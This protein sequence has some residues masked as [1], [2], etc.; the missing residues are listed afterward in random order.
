MK[1]LRIGIV[2]DV[3]LAQE[4]LKRFV[5]SVNEFEV[6]WVAA[7]GREA[8]HK[9]AKDTPDLILMD[10]IMPEMDGVAATR[11]IMKASPC[12]ILIVTSS[13]TENSPKVFEAMGCGALDVVM[14]PTIALTHD[15]KAESGL[16]K[17]IATIAQLL[18]KS[19]S[20][21]RAEPKSASL[22]IE[23]TPP[24]R[25]PP[26]VVIGSSTGGPFALSKVLSH[27]PRDTPCSFVVIQHIDE[28]FAPGF[29]KW[30]GDQISLPVRIARSGDSIKKGEVLVAG[31]DDHLV[32]SSGLFLKYTPIPKET[33]YR[34]SVDLFFESVA[35]HWPSPSVAILLTGMGDD[36]ARG[37]KALFQA[38]WHTIAE[39]QNSCVVYG[40]P[41]AAVDLGAVKQVLLLEK[42]ASEAEAIALK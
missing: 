21:L 15:P 42:I 38:G 10:L 26:L 28:R 24:S 22:P 14:T 7:D 17:K 27:F 41:K 20:T 35:R 39:H 1:K 23:K 36:G 29:A 2:N 18:G 34:P 25:V 4:V 32:L 5:N 9:A 30:L 8:V 33:P 40:M 31:S 12:A 16:Y 6:A 19:I 11:E 13:P 37:M 3:R